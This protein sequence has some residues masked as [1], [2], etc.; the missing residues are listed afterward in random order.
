MENFTLN[1]IGTVSVRDNQTM[2][3]LDKKYVSA[4]TGLDGFG[5]IQILWCFNHCDNET[6]RSKMTSK[7]PYKKGPDVLGMFAT[8]SPERPNPIALSCAYVTHID[9]DNGIIGLAYIDAHD[10]TP[11]F[12]IKPYIPSLDRV[13][14][15]KMPDWCK[16]WPNCIEKSGDFNWEDEFNF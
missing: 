6:A 8:R 2:I 11:V 15:P 3:E 13:E 4:L 9:Y 1:V 7:K 14:N 5:Y 16:H 12:D 10:G